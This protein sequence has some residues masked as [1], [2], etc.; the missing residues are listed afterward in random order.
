MP[1]RLAISAI[2]VALCLS[3]APA[4][5]KTNPWA[6]AKRETRTERLDRPMDRLQV[7]STIDKLNEETKEQFGHTFVVKYYLDLGPLNRVDVNPDLWN[8]LTAAQRRQVGGKF[9]KAF[10][11]TGLL[12]CQFFVDDARVGKVRADPISGGLKFEMEE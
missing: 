11:G 8:S 9:A 1:G 3:L 6:V 7:Q 4:A 5:Q 2:V 10:K 12:C